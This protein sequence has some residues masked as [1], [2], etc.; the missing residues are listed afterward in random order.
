MYNT[1]F[2]PGTSGW[3]WQKTKQKLSNIFRLKFH[4]LK[5]I[6]FLHPLYYSKIIGHIL[7][8]LQINKK[9]ACFNE[10]IWLIIMKI[11]MKMK[12]GSH[13]FDIIGSH[14]LFFLVQIHSRQGW[15]ATTR[16]GLTRKTSTKRLEHAG[17][18]FRKNLQLKDVC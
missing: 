15:T 10:I 16:H 5:I 18:L 14:R 6:R 1:H 2:L 7:K 3:N 9:C 11:K 12:N 4:Y 17:N 8:Y 13:R